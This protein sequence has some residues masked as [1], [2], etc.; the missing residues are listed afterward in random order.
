[1][2]QDGAAWFLVADGRRARLLIEPRRGAQLTEHWSTEISEDELYDPQDRRPRDSNRI[3]Y[4]KH[5]VGNDRNL[6]EAEEEKFLKR[7]A[8]MIGDADKQNQFDHLIIAAP[9]R[10]LGLLRNFLPANAQD[11]LC[12]TTPKDLVDEDVPRLRER[13]VDLL[14]Q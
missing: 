12:A 4:G 8:D 7:V 3:G 9:P 5:T 2:L 11:R 1:M 6:H 14:R 13:L 10:A